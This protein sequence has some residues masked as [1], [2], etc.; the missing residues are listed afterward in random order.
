MSDEKYFRIRAHRPKDR[1]GGP[2]PKVLLGKWREPAEAADDAEMWLRAFGKPGESFCDLLY[3]GDI[4]PYSSV[5]YISPGVYGIWNREDNPW[6]ID[7]IDTGMT[8]EMIPRT[9]LE[10]HPHFMATGTDDPITDDEGKRKKGEEAEV[11][12]IDSDDDEDDESDF[13]DE[14]D[15]E[16]AYDDDEAEGSEDAP[17]GGSEG[18]NDGDEGEDGEEDDEDESD[19]GEEDETD[20]EMES[21]D[22]DF[23]DEQE[24]EQDMPRLNIFAK[25]RGP[26]GWRKRAEI[27]DLNERNVFGFKIGVVDDSK[28]TPAKQEQDVVVFVKFVEN[29]AERDAGY[30]TVQLPRGVELERQGIGRYVARVPYRPEDDDE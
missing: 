26:K 5:F 8:G 15:W 24:A 12:K 22:D 29:N 20:D 21:D 4:E 7:Y 2:W 17:D 23:S 10:L 27:E 18:D 6:P 25:M 28:P 16:D 3:N 30:L 9:P 13:E 19:D 1:D 14:D 11:L